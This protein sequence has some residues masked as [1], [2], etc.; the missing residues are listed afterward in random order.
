MNILVQWGPTTGAEPAAPNESQLDGLPPLVEQL[1]VLLSP[2]RGR[3]AIAVDA[4]GFT[5]APAASAEPE[6]TP[7]S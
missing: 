2:L 3:T 6:A 7:A 1:D 4:P 5:P